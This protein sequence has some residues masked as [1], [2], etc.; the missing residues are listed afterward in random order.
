M[1]KVTFESIKQEIQNALSQKLK[2]VP[3]AGETTGFTL[4]DGFINAPLQQEIG[5]SLVIGGPAVPMVAIVGNSTGRIYY[6]ALKALLP[7]LNFSQT[8]EK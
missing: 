1:K 4:V 3:F 2:G 5:G 7:K 8:E 6:F